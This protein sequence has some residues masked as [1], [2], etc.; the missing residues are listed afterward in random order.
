MG[1]AGIWWD[2]TI[3]KPL[4]SGPSASKAPLVEDVWNLYDVLDK[5]TSNLEP[6]LRRTRLD[7]MVF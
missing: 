3:G 4:G 7:H 5:K 2:E 1:P 6:D